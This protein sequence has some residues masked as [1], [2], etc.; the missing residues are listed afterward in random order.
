MWDLRSTNSRE[1]FKVL[2]TT[3]GPPGSRSRHL[4]IKREPSIGCSE[5][6]SL[7]MSFVFK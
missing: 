3:G 2:G 5:S 4:G 6:V 7:R 1:L